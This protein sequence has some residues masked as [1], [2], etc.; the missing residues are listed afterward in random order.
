MNHLLFDF[1]EAK[2]AYLHEP[3]PSYETRCERIKRLLTMINENEEN[4]CKAIS[5]DFGQRNTTETKF[6]EL[7][8]IRQAA[9][10]TLKHLK[11]WM[12]PTKVKTPFHLR[13]SVSQLIPESIGIV[14]IMSPWN[15]P[16]Q[17]AIIP[18]ISAFAAGNR[19][20][21][22]P[23]ERSSRTSGYLASLITHYFHPSE[24]HIVCG[25][26]D[27]SQKFAELP[28]DH[29]LFTGSTEAG[30]AIMR[31]ASSNLTPVTLELG[32]KSPCVIDSKVNLADAVSRIVYGKFLNAGQTCIAPDYLLIPHQHLDQF[33]TL[34]KESSKKMYPRPAEQMTHPID[35]RQLERWQFLVTDA[36]AKGAQVEPVFNSEL[37]D[38]YPF[39]PALV[40]NP[41]S[42][43]LLMKEEIFG[44]ILPVISYETLEEAIHFINRFERPLALYWF[45]KDNDAMSQVLEL[46]RAG[47]VTINDTLLHI[48]NDDLP[49]GGIGASGI[50]AY[51]GKYGFDTFTHYKPV[52]TMKARFGIKALGGSK[53]IHPP[54]GKK[55]ARLIKMLSK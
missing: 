44:P 2:K 6:A 38:T 47:G 53:F 48:A 50:G 15:Y 5:A 52:F 18:I 40:I 34:F 36:E 20:W 17:L 43:S 42:D 54:Y 9:R 1:E 24:L 21:L 3:N 32:G 27:I 46:T 4:I 7:T 51:H 14:G 19:V 55:I 29:L 31:A 22:K 33:L 26:K 13:P 41:S 37:L 35:Q 8:F 39:N 49:F 16:V 45:G 12:K 23:S 10:H 30:K 28:F 11:Q 25:E